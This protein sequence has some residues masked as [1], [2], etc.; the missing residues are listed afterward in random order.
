M[1]NSHPQL[2][3]SASNKYQENIKA[4]VSTFGGHIYFDKG[5][6]GS[7]KR[8]IQ[9]YTDVGVFLDYIKTYPSSKSQS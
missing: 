7:Y 9:S 3:A 2:T 8:R 1:K 4:F 6:Y 5:S